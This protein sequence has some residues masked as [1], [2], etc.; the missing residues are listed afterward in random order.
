MK[1]WC[2]SPV[3]SLGVGGSEGGRGR[4]GVGRDSSGAGP[5]MCTRQSWESVLGAGTSSLV[6]LKLL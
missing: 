2:G 5:V 3:S 1:G 6:V 4:G